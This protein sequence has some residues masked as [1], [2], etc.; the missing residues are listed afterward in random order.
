MSKPWFALIASLLPTFLMHPMAGAFAVTV[1]PEEKQTTTAPAD[2][3]DL[4][5]ALEKIRSRQGI[6]ALA[7]AVLRDGQ[8]ID[9][10]AIGFRAGKKGPRVT[11]DDRFHLGSCTKSMT[12]T[13][14]A[15][16]VEQGKL[17]WDSTIGNVFPSLKDK[18]NPKFHPVTLEQLLC[19]RSGLPDDH[20]PDLI[21]F[22]QIMSL[23]GDMQLQRRELVSIV[24][25]REPAT[26]P[27][28]AYAYSNYGF[29]IAGAMC[30]AVMAEPYETLMSKRLFEPL[31][32]SSAGFGA[33]G[34]ADKIDQ[35]RGH[36][37]LFTWHSPVK[38]G[39]GSDNP[40]VIGPAG[41]AHA[42][43]GDWAKYAALHLDALRGKPRILKKESFDR[44]HS[45]PFK[46]EY[47]F[48]WAQ[49]DRDWADG[50]MF[51]HDG[52]NGRWYAMVILA[53]KKNTALLVATNAGSDA[54]VKACQRA[55]QKLQAL[56][57]D[58]EE[59]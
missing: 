10:A 7:A 45:D 42:S 13:L 17:K 11:P 51:A 32:M 50:K 49:A 43:L 46:Q 14:C 27:G 52:S 22:P 15:I 4:S 35:P 34:C 18:I 6:P 16:L 1:E 59:P 44:L 40:A 47:G 36:N 57:L 9:I 58:S 5:G 38:P 20:V 25:N 8:L 2:A 30:E 3:D 39:P 55:M 29:A 19:H 41:T 21:L 54:A 48:G 28:Y 24:L 26:S 23:Q 37:K 56:Y 53:P 31:G 12:A 33:P